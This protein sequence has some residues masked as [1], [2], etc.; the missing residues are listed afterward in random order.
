MPYLTEHWTQTVWE[1]L[2]LNEKLENENIPI[3]FCNIA[4]FWKKRESKIH[5]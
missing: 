1:P 3:S 4:I 5:R 2:E